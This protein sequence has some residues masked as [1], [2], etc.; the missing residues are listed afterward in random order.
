MN[1]N[2]WE[3]SHILGMYLVHSNSVFINM[4][5]S[6]IVKAITNCKAKGYPDSR[7][8]KK[9]VTFYITHRHETNHFINAI[10]APWLVFNDELCSYYMSS[11][12]HALQRHG[13]G[14]LHAPLA[15]SKA[16]LKEDVT[17]RVERAELAQILQIMMVAEIPPLATVGDLV[18]MLNG[19]IG[20][21]AMSRGHSPERCVT[22]TTDLP[23]GQPI[24]KSHWTVLNIMEALAR[25]S[26][27]SLLDKFRLDDRAFHKWFGPAFGTDDEDLFALASKPSNEVYEVYAKTYLPL[28]ADLPSEI[29]AIALTLSLRG[30]FFPFLGPGKARLEDFHP[31]M[32]LERMRADCAEM[33]R[34]WRRS[35][36]GFESARKQWLAEKLM[37]NIIWG[38]DYAKHLTEL[39]HEVIRHLRTKYTLV[40]N[41]DDFKRNRDTLDS[42]FHFAFPNVANSDQYKALKKELARLHTLRKRQMNNELRD[43]LATIHDPPIQS[44][45]YFA[46][47]HIFFD[48]HDKEFMDLLRENGPLF[49]HDYRLATVA[50]GEY[51][52]FGRGEAQEASAAWGAVVKSMDLGRI[53]DMDPLKRLRDGFGIVC[54]F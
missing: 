30:R 24:S 1:A 5:R 3:T 11:L 23:A 14:T 25:L 37:G 10:C 44:D 39:C 48:D 21:I 46:T 52:V 19:F 12:L 36:P 15:R 40:D 42:R 28:I 33:Y 34:E 18:T 4:K 35:R 27:V 26:E 29:A 16:R 2:R 20:E 49:A 45:R 47:D 41:V 7:H 50:M 9:L 54:K 53:A 51:A 6:D 38:G 32:L 43:L 31:V 13:P 17:E 22:V 8:D